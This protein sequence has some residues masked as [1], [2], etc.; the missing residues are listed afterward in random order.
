LPLVG[1]STIIEAYGL[2]GFSAAASPM[3]SYLRGERIEVAIER[4]RKMASITAGKNPNYLI[5]YLDFDGAPLGIDVVKVEQTQVEPVVH[6]GIPLMRGG[7][8]GIGTAKIPLL[9]FQ[10]AYQALLEIDE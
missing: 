7:Q 3:V 1:D 9:C 8:A 2:G 4:S 5:P 10:A 6:A